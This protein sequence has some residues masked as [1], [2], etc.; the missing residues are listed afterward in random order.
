M[1]LCRNEGSRPNTL[2]MLKSVTVEIQCILFCSREAQQIT[3]CNGLPIKYHVGILI[4]FNIFFLLYLTFFQW[5]ADVVNPVPIHQGGFPSTTDDKDWSATGDWATP[6]SPPPAGP[7][8]AATT[9][10][11][12]TSDWGGAGAENWN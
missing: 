12:T 5:A 9:T 4:E 6:V 11:T 2:Y 8:P 10:T 7:A 1:I 3:I